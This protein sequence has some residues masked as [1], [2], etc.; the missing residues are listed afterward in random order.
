MNGVLPARIALIPELLERAAADW[1]DRTAWSAANAA[2]TTAATRPRC[3]AARRLR[4]A[5]PP[6]ARVATLLGNSDLA[7][8]LTLALQMAGCQHV[9]LNPLYTA[10]ELDFILRDAQPA[11]LIAD[12]ASSALAAPLA[13]AQG[14]RL[15]DG[16]AARAWTI[17]S[18]ETPAAAPAGDADAPALL[19]Y[20][21]GT[22][23]QPKGVILSRAAIATNVFQREAV[24]PTRHGAET[25][26]C[27]MPLFHSYGMAMGL[28][29]AASA[30]ATLVVLPRYRPDDV[31]DA[32]A[33]ERVTLFPG[34]PTIYAGLMA[35]A[36]F[37]QTDW[38][39]V[40]V[41]YSG[42]APLAEETLRRWEAAVGAPI[43]EGYGQ[44]E[45]GPILTYNGP[46][47]S[48]AGSVGRPVPGTEVEVVDLETGAKPLLAGQRGEIR[49]RP[50]DHARLS[51]APRGHRRIT[52][53]R[54]AL[55]RRHRRI[56]RGWLPVHPRPQ[57]GPGDRRRL[58][59]LS[60][61]GR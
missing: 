10:R 28:F 24:L 34:S 53:R 30:A 48:R 9:P 32:V 47:G 23:G 57:E 37:A 41:C 27:A 25:V 22:T 16:A 58:Q 31:F 11:L 17:P 40:R 6:G 1:P 60:A 35:H 61:R 56:R 26:L 50:A 54:L 44:T 5:L 46:Q 36:R 43:Y 38:S 42:S 18:D 20:T 52:A 51:G 13:A 7:C 15:L 14:I 12:E 59:R 29:L 3:A 19:Q 8:V 33:R 45:A 2:S 4:Q 21:G 55:H 39:S 49:A